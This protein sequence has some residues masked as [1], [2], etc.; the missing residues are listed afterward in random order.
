[1]ASE[2]TDATDSRHASLVSPGIS[3]A[4]AEDPNRPKRVMGFRDLL[5]FYVVTGIS[6]RWIATA[7]AA[8]PSS[9]HAARSFR[10]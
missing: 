4:D 5:L 10:N 3:V 7:A 6:L 2:P 1:M 9:V 8:G